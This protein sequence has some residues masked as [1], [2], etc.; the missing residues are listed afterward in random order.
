[1]STFKI[2][3]IAGS[4]MNAQNA[5]L[6]LVASNIA[7]AETIS[8]SIDKTYKSRQPV[9]ATQLA[10]AIDLVGKAKAK[11]DGATGVKVLGVVESKAPLRMEYQ[12]DHPMANAD[13][14][15]FKPN[16]NTMEEMANM[17]AA[18]RGYEDNVNV[19]NTAKQLIAQTL[20]MGE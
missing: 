8:S 15:I 4:G 6:N 10:D 9:F 14:Y 17:I 7:N 1:M 11:N 18:S 5:R 16:V 3:D 19:F 2:F 20:R 12:P 13:G